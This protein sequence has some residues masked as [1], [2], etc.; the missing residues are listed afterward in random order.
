[1]NGAQHWRESRTE[2]WVTAAWAEGA[3]KALY[4]RNPRAGAFALEAVK[5]QADRVWADPLWVVFPCDIA[6]SA[7]VAVGCSREVLHRLGSLALGDAED[8]GECAA[9]SYRELITQAT[10]SVGAALRSK[11]AAEARFSGGV[12]VAE[13]HDASLAVEFAF[14]IDGEKCSIALAP[15]E[16]FLDAIGADGAAVELTV[17]EPQ[18]RV[19]PEQ[20]EAEAPPEDS[21]GAAHRNLEMLLELEMEV[22]VSFGQTEMRLKDVLKLSVGSIVELQCQ[23]SDPVEVLVNDT[24]IARGEVVVV[25]S[26]YGVRITDVSS[27]RERIQSIF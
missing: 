12:D 15:N 13:P 5:P 9:E 18:D 21:G 4:Q 16:A 17:E 7:A 19:R 22:A 2:H 14:E 6:A 8:A 20:P 3:C 23:A 1:M 26:N 27:R 11:S 10:A 25:D 24:V